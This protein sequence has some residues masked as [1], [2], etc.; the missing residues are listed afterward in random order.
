MEPIK[1]NDENI[2]QHLK[3]MPPIKD[4]QSKQELFLKVQA[5]IEYKQPKGKKLPTWSLPALATACALVL[6]GIFVPDLMKN[7]GQ[8]MENSN[9][10]QHDG[11]MKAK[12]ADDSAGG[13]DKNQVGLMKTERLAA[14]HSPLLKKDIDSSNKDWVTIG[15]LDE[16][17]QLVIP[18]SFLTDKDY[19]LNK[20]NDQLQKFKPNDAGLTE[21]PLIKAKIT[22]EEETVIVDFPQGAVLESEEPL[23]KSLISIT[24]ANSGQKAKVE[25][26]TDG[27]P[28]YEF[29]RFGPAKEWDLAVPGAPHYRYD[30]PSND[31]FI[32]SLFSTGEEA[33]RLPKEF[34]D[35]L[36][37]MDDEQERGLKP[38]L[39][40]NITFG[41]KE[42]NKDY[43]EITFPDS[44]KLSADD[45]E[46]V[47]MIDA[48]LL[49][50]ESYGY[51][52]VKFMNTKLDTIGPYHLDK[53]IEGVTG[54]NF[55]HYQ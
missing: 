29:P 32:V 37:M 9:M 24:F 16:Q 41:V 17:A 12:M 8:K 14:Y 1:W 22:E 20:V 23:L 11:D 49:T 19:Y 46:D 34:K 51:D 40:K 48:I 35:A 30:A 5:K 18:V 15:Y 2:E 50:A 33:D 6:F 13:K 55:Y 54:T 26:R 38:L 52:S 4:R 7:G 47:M 28:G 42:I 21:S 43:V 53:P 31:A 44:I 27:Q 45:T 25:F 3:S 10:A 36:E 39:P